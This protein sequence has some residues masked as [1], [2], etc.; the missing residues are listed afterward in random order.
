M[1]VWLPVLM[2]YYTRNIYFECHLKK[3]IHAYLF[4]LIYKALISDILLTSI[5]VC[6]RLNWWNKIT[7]FFG[8]MVT[9]SFS[10]SLIP[11][12]TLFSSSFHAFRFVRS[13]VLGPLKNNNWWGRGREAPLFKWLLIHRTF[14]YWPK[15]TRGRLA[16][17]QNLLY[18]L[19]NILKQERS[20]KYSFLLKRKAS[21][22]TI[23][24]SFFFLFFK[25]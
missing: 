23:S 9:C 19:W 8:G 5:S 20:F 18:L 17:S 14:S 7:I 3:V 1:C 22:I 12:A 25:H 10:L 2:Y 6:W 21:S 16:S 4:H 24:S 11:E 15:H 13:L